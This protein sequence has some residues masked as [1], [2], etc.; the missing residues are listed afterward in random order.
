MTVEKA[1]GL[2]VKALERQIPT[3]PRERTECYPIGQYECSKCKCGLVANDKW[4]TKY[5]PECGQAQ[6][7][8]DTE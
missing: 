5:C 6:D 3:K 8:S 7:W 4:K 2:A 1:I